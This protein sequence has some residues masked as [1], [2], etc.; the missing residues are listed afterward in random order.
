MSASKPDVIE[1]DYKVMPEEPSV[2]PR[3]CPEPPPLLRDDVLR[4]VRTLVAQV[5]GLAAAV[6]GAALA[7]GRTRPVFLT[8]WRKW[9]GAFL[10]DAQRLERSIFK[11]QE[12][13]RRVAGYA[14]RLV[15]WRQA[16]AEELG[17]PAAVG[18]DA[19]APAAAP[20]G[21]KPW[22]WFVWIPVGFGSVVGAYMSVRWVFR[23]CLESI[24]TAGDREQE[25]HAE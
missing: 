8:S 6:E 3:P 12:E 18:A 7:P 10:A 2:E 25:G 5:T 23:K 11:E 24:D 21:K 14:G 22:P 16:L 19:P 4:A 17:A 9:C 15:E 1:A 20:T 13:A